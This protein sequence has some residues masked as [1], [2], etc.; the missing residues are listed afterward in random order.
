VRTIVYKRLE[1]ISQLRYRA[2][3]VKEKFMKSL[4]FS[5]LPICRDFSVAAR[6]EL[7]TGKSTKEE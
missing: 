5:N 3:I 2:T 1:E 4:V 6:V 7:C